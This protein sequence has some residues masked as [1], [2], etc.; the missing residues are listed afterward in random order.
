METIFKPIRMTNMLWMI[1]Y[2][3]KGFLL[4]SYFI[5]FVPIS[6]AMF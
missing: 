5:G 3:N 6:Y 4:T 2:F 1:Y